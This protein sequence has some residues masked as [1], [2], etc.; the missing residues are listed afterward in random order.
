MSLSKS[1]SVE[2]IAFEDIRFH[3]MPFSFPG[4]LSWQALFAVLRYD[5]NLPG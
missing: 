2:D 4:A 1:S 5:S 3:R